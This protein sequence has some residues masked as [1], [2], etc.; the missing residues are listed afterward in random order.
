MVEK[1]AKSANEQQD[2]V[3]EGNLPAYASLCPIV[4]YK[5]LREY[6]G[7]MDRADTDDVFHLRC[8]YRNA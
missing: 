8:H 2:P 1:E 3:L 7:F 4:G 6:M 5:I